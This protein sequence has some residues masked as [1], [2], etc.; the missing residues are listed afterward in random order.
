MLIRRPA[1]SPARGVVISGSKS[2][3]YDYRQKILSLEDQLENL[4]I[5]L[6]KAL[7]KTQSM[8]KSLEGAV[9]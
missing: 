1:S 4:G 2:K 8:R 9:S 3:R 6:K 7:D 5:M